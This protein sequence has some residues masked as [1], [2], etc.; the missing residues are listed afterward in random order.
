MGLSVI[1]ECLR[2]I[3]GIH[4]HFSVIVMNV[5]RKATTL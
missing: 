4:V 5:T 1:K 2:I 3:L